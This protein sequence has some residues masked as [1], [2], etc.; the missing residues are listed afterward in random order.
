MSFPASDGDPSTAELEARTNGT[1]R[2]WRGISGIVY[3][4]RHQ[5]S[6]PLVLRDE[7][8]A[9]LWA[10]MLVKDPGLAQ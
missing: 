4:R 2:V 8:T 6:P 5:S 10:Q 3:A 9:E 7:N 1:W